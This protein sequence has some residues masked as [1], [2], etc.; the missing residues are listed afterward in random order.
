[1][2]EN[3]NDN[4]WFKESKNIGAFFKHSAAEN[5]EKKGWVLYEVH[6]QPR[7]ARCHL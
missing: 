2:H 3:I 1:M 6:D 4:H 7:P 5:N